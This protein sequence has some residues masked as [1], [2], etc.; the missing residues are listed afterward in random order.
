MDCTPALIVFVVSV[1]AILYSYAL[2]PLLLVV[3]PKRR[4]EPPADPANWPPV[5]VLVS[6][7]NE[8]KHIAERIENL[9]ALD[10]PRDKLQILI[11]SDGSTDK[12]NEIVGSYSDPRVKLHT[13]SPREGK[14][15]VLNDLMAETTGELLVFTDA[16]TMF[17][18]D[19]LR[20]LVR[21]FSNPRIGG[22]CGRLVL[23][24]DDSETSEGPYWKL[25][26]F[27]KE[28]ESAI[29]SC[30]GA[31]GGIYAIRKSAW[32]GIPDNTL[33]DDFVIAMRVREMGLRVVY[34]TEAV[35]TEEVPESVEHEMTRRIRIG[36]GGFQA[37]LLCWPSLLPW[38]GFY[39]FAFW[40]HKVLRW[41]GPFF[42]IAALVANV[43]LLP[44]PFFTGLLVL[45]F[46]F[47]ALATLGHL[48]RKKHFLLL[49]APH[50]FVVINFALLLGF[51][52][53]I[54]GSQRAAWKRTVR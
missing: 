37:M 12:T 51:L 54:T 24:G 1:A 10:Y 15:S 11:G 47:Y 28:Q 26:T 31:N 17:A 46:T 2:Y 48:V 21:H 22:V 35:A 45:Q 41:L 40:S 3:L 50:Y 39:S 53:F 19:A 32:R 43:A 16:N 20:K 34:D 30:L 4:H 36:A 23:H 44:H 38:R 29:D 27:L 13:F 8:E 9:L 5:S 49:S 25:E 6:V 18:R 14:P 42:M 33:V 7:Y 52:R